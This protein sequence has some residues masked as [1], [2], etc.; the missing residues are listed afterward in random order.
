MNLCIF[1]CSCICIR[2]WLGLYSEHNLPCL[3]LYCSRWRRK[4]VKREVNVLDDLRPAVNHCLATRFQPPSGTTWK[5]ETCFIINI[6]IIIIIIIIMN[7]FL[8]LIMISVVNQCV[9]FEFNFSHLQARFQEPFSLIEFSPSPPSSSSPWQSFSL[10]AAG[11]QLC[12]WCFST[13]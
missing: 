5:L 2:I 7:L 3:H 8:F 10:E 11:S 6:I 4:A 12:F 13:V 1:S 9:V